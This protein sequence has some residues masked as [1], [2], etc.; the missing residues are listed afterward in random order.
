MVQRCNKCGLEKLVNEFFVRNT[1]TGKLHSECKD[2]YK[3]H[4]QTYYQAHYKKYRDSYL[5]RANVRREKLKTEFHTNMLAYLSDKSCVICGENDQRVLE[6]DHIEP[7]E[8]KF[9]I[10]QAVKLGFAW[11]EV[12]LEIAKCQVLCSNCHKKRTA[13]QYGWYKII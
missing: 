13:E 7:A 6:F 12:K 9:S 2:C 8:K 5:K 11:E 4:R 3:V 10:S 1:R